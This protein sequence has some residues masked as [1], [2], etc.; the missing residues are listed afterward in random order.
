MEITVID[1]REEDEFLAGHYE[2]AL[3]IP[4]STI[5]SNPRLGE[6]SKDTPLVLYCRSGGRSEKALQ[7][8]KK[9]GYSNLTNGINQTMLE[10][11][12]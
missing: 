4:L 6:L 11:E 12:S 1:V 3:N 5:P 7:A 9:L 8:L 2:G 10:R